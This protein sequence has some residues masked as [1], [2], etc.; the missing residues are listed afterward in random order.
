MD[1][2]KTDQI[3]G[4]IA[5]E[6]G[7]LSP[8]QLAQFQREV[9][10]KFHY[11]LSLSNFLLLKSALTAAQVQEIQRELER[12][13][14]PEQIGDYQV[15]K[16]I[17]V[18]AMGRVYKVRRHQQIYA[19][20]VIDKTR[21]SSQMDASRFIREIQMVLGLNHPHIVRAYDFGIDV[22]KDIYFVVL[23]YIHGQSVGQ[24]I[25]QV[26]RIHPIKALEITD[27]VSQAIG[28]AYQQG[29]V[30]RDIKPENILLGEGKLIKLADFGLAKDLNAEQLTLPGT[31]MGTPHYVAPEILGAE[32]GLTWATDIYS[33][34]ISL[35]H[36][37][38]GHPPFSGKD[39]QQTIAAHLF[40]ELPRLETTSLSLSKNIL[41]RLQSLLDGMTRK[42]PHER[43]SIES[44]R[45]DVQ[46]IIAM[47][48][49]EDFLE[50]LKSNFQFKRKAQP[51]K[52]LP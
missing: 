47:I 14:I 31:L 26:G 50:K 3:F 7:Y 22:E 28:Y 10:Q 45:R 29:I 42:L 25:K 37:L 27:A 13:C 23:E 41:Q 4:E 34:G 9:G 6:K 2:R 15:L 40:E 36:M 43:I 46:E 17:G 1:Q 35:F 11:R 33:L 39:V 21:A 52:D 5:L 16:C 48:K 49:R 44:L 51:Y 38:C 18:G 20:K 8:A 32:G 12:R 19:L 24:I 30:H